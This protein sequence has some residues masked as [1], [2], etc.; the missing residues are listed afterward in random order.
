MRC[1]GWQ[2]RASASIITGLPI[3]QIQVKQDE[4][5]RH[6][7]AAKAVL[8]LVEALGGVRVGEVVDGPLR[9]PLVLRLPE[10]SL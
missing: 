5:A 8:D 2:S 10:R 1:L 7:I 3:L 6:G 4:L 9:F